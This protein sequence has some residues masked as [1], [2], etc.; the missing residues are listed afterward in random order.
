LMFER[1][2]K[3]IREMIG[4][5]RHVMRVVSS[6]LRRSS[7]S[8]T[9]DIG[10][11]DYAFWDKARRGKA[12]GLEISGL[13]IKPLASKVAAWTLGR[14]PTWKTDDTPSQEALNKWW[15]KNHADVLRSYREAI[16]LGDHFV[17]INSDLSV[18]VIDPDVVDPIVDEDDYSQIVGWRITQVYEHPDR[19]SDRMLITDEY[20]AT[21]RVRTVSKNGA[22]QTIERF[23]NMIGLVPIVHIPNPGGSDEVFGRPEGEA[24]IPALQK[25]GDVITAGIDGIIRQGHST[26]VI[27]FNTVAALDKFW[28]LYGKS[29]TKTLE[30]GTTEKT[31]YVEFD[32]DQLVTISEAVFDWK[33]PASFSVD[34]QNL[35]GLL[36]YLLLQHT[37]I[38]EFIWGNAIASSQ[39]SAE[40]QLPPFIMYIEMK[41]G[42]IAKWLTQIGEVV[43]SYLSLTEPG[44]RAQRPSPQ[45]SSLAGDDKR[46]TLDTIQ[47]AFSEGLLDKRTALALSPVDIEDIDGV[48]EKAEEEKAA[49]VPEPLR[50]F[51]PLTDGNMMDNEVARLEGS[52]DGNDGGDN[53]S[54]V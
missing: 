2:T 52:N 9:K 23:P 7:F 20:T 50:S 21:E 30:D 4:V 54:N 12:A 14:K 42:D 15:N 11:T 38:P 29:S 24:L 36:F 45:F 8:P 28:E 41:Q 32:A 37:E 40:A 19:P 43:L 22:Q 5:T 6:R 49:L 31:N 53:A 34:T 16:A 46:L 51:N 10:R 17:V 33:S 48:L 27:N 35:L 1:I 26:P 47:W 44:V 13:F 39:A 3:R 25:Y 18:T